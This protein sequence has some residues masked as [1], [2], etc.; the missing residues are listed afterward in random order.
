MLIL[1]LKVETKL[2]EILNRGQFYFWS[3]GQRTPRFSPANLNFQGHTAS[4]FSC[5]TFLP[6]LSLSL[7]FAPY[8]AHTLDWKNARKLK[9]SLALTLAFLFLATIA[10]AEPDFSRLADAIYKAEGGS[11]TSH[12]YGILKKFKSTSPR[13]ACL[14]T[15]H[16]Q[17]RLW[18]ASGSKESYVAFLGHSY[19]PIGALNDPLNLN[20]NWISNVEA[21]YGKA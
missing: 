21:L 16:H 11:K 12:P 3:Y 17:Y 7:R 19:A 8:S 2:K 13:A 5:Q 20:S 18:V 15:L 4:F 1:I 6:S 9:R 14:N 10:S